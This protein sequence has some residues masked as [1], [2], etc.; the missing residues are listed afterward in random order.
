MQRQ[1]EMKQDLVFPY[2][3]FVKKIVKVVIYSRL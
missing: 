3:I 2:S 1:A